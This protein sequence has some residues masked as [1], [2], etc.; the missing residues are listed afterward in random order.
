M[1]IYLDHNAGA[2]LHGVARAAMTAALDEFGN[3]SSIHTRGRRARALLERARR[4]V[5]GLLGDDTDPI[6]RVVFTSGGT[7]ALFAALIGLAAGA[8]PARGV[9]LVAS[10]HPAV[11]GAAAALAERGWRVHVI[12]VDA[13]GLIDPASWADALAHRPA[14]VALAA[15]NHELGTIA[16]IP[17]L[18]PAARAVGA[19]VVVDAIAAAGR[20]ELGPIAAVA[21]AVALSSHKLGGPAGVGALWTAPG[22]T[23][24]PPHPGGHQERGRRPGTENLLGAIGF[25]AAAA[26]VDLVEAAAVPARA[27]RLEAAIR[28]IPGAHVHG[29]GAVRTG[30]TVNAR[31]DGV[32]GETLVMALDLAGV[33]ASAGAACSSGSVAPSPVLLALGLDPEAA[34]GG[35]RL[36]LGP[37]TTDAEVDAVAALLPTL[38]ARARAAG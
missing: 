34:R 1:R 6:D 3:P 13:E 24:A 18:A 29:A 28:A 32:R 14:I 26:A 10:E 8:A 37:S 17:A 11:H 33:D 4:Q 20:V 12:A 35:L 21:D 23:L 30:H 5:A 36:S 7:E 31:F 38:V 15:A 25:G 2:P 27:A 19:R 9:A 22:V 16:D